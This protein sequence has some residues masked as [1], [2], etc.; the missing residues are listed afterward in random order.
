MLPLNALFNFGQN[1]AA[2]TVLSN[3]SPISYSVATVT[4]RIVII[5]TSLLLLR[6]PVTSYN[7]LGMFIAIAGI[8]FYN[9]VSVCLLFHTYCDSND[10][11]QNMKAIKSQCNYPLTLMTSLTA[12]VTMVI[13]AARGI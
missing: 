9:M 2:F 4:K 6:N 5:V 1:I 12:A 13:V 10:F 8:A 7:M 3:V 11:R